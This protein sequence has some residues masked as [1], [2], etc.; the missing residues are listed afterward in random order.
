MRNFIQKVSKRLRIGLIFFKSRL[1]YLYKK[2]LAVIAVCLLA[3]S[4]LYF[5]SVPTFKNQETVVVVRF[6]DEDNPLKSYRSTVNFY[7]DGQET[8]IDIRTWFKGKGEME[9][10]VPSWFK[11]QSLFN[12]G[13]ILS[14]YSGSGNLK[15]AV[16]WI[17]EKVDDGLLFQRFRANLFL[18][19]NV[20]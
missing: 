12:K 3:S 6:F 16:F 20:E 14:D 1:S 11:E 10:I 17:D 7:N 9:L 8:I 15:E 5:F 18:Q 13:K 19:K 2:E 4:T